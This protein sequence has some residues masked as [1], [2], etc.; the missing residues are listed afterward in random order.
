MADID[1]IYRN[2]RKKE[3]A[4]IREQEMQALEKIR[5]E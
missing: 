4:K 3:L 5:K 1:I 2:D